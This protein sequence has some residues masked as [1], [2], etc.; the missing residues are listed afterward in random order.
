MSAARRSPA[1]AH[2]EVVPQQQQQTHAHLPVLDSVLDYEKLH[3]IG[4]GT[5][6]VVYKGTLDVLCSVTPACNPHKHLVLHTGLVSRSQTVCQD[7]HG[8]HHPL[9]LYTNHASRH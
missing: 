1:A 7:L 5:Y 2:A 3:R 8:A 4:E 9:C 6:G